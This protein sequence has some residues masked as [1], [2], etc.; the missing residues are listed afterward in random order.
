MKRAI[1]LALV[2][3]A[4]AAA[5]TAKAA[6]NFR[7]DVQFLRKYSDARILKSADGKGRLA[8]MEI[9][10]GTP[11]IANLIREGKTFQIPS[12]I[13]TGRKQGMVALDDAIMEKLNKK[14]ISAEEAFDKCVDKTKFLPFLK[15][16]PADYFG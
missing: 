11:A 12:I 4:L 8:A 9:M 5:G 1:A 16:T 10:V 6:G 2:G 15:E 3:A 13:Q 7:D 14:W